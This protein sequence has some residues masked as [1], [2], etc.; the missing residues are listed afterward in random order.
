MTSS[1]PVPPVRWGVVLGAMVAGFVAGEVLGTL[2]VGLLAGIYHYPGGLSALA[3]ASTPP[4]WFV[5]GSLV[6]L[7]AG[8]AGAIYLARSRGHLAPLAGQWR[9]R[10]GDAVYVVLG[11]ALQFG[12][13][14]AYRPWHVSHLN[15]PVTHLFGGASGASAVLIGVMTLLG[16]PFME[17]MFFRGLVFRG[18]AGAL[19]ARERGLAMWVAVIGS[20]LL[21][22][23]AHGEAAQ[24]AGLAA[25]GVVLAVLVVRTQRLAPSFLTHASFNA[26]ALA[27]LFGQRIH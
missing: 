20:A 25:V 11:V 23:L 12:V 7:W 14:L 19:H 24:F 4:W 21:F 13:D 22:A 9:F 15:Q 2:L 26:V 8:F 1:A 17:E 6:G 18:L 27:A 16:A 5:A 3:H 10:P